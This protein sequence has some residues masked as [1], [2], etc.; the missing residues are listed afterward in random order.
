MEK[1]VVNLVYKVDIKKKRCGEIK[2][3]GK[4]QRWPHSLFLIMPLIFCHNSGKS[5][6]LPEKKHQSRPISV[7]HQ[8]WFAV[9]IACFI[10]IYA[11][12]S[13]CCFQS[14]SVKWWYHFTV[15]QEFCVSKSTNT[16][17]TIV[18]VISDIYMCK[19]HYFNKM[20][21]KSMQQE[22]KHNNS[23]SLSIFNTSRLW[24]LGSHR[25][26]KRWREDME[27]IQW[28]SLPFPLLSM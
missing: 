4:S 18:M 2:G 21:W 17:Q 9:K 7:E 19:A 23:I 12:Y 8:C 6:I 13:H 15:P 3:V 16:V 14:Q 25:E 27:G 11:F 20:L 28:V 1:A 26:K 24:F 5:L 10:K 22:A